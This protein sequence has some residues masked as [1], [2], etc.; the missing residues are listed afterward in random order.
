MSYKPRLIL[1]IVWNN[2]YSTGAE[3]A[4]HI[5][6][7]LCRDA[8]R[9]ASRGLGIPVYFHTGSTPDHAKLPN[10]LELDS[11]ES[12]I[13]IPLLDTSIRADAAWKE[14]VRNIER[15]IVTLGKRHLFLPIACE[16]RVLTVV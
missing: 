11:A 1:R 6:S 5:Y 2:E 15:Q 4:R 3:Y 13:V 10:S 14:C 7:R 16:D 9:P 12:T 8:E